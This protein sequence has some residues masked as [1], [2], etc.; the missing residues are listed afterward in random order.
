MFQKTELVAHPS[1]DVVNGN[2]EVVS[3]D[4]HL[5]NLTGNVSHDD[6]VMRVITDFK[7]RAGMVKFH[8]KHLPTKVI[9][10]LFETYCMPLYVLKT[11]CYRALWCGSTNKSVM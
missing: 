5:D 3:Q 7:K 11:N 4:V 9:H 8:F 10:S 6:F 2:T 1:D